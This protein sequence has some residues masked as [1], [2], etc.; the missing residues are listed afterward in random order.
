MWRLAI[1]LAIAAAAVAAFVRGAEIY[2]FRPY[3]K[4]LCKVMD[5]SS[6]PECVFADSYWEARL[7]FR[8]A[9]DDAVN[10]GVSAELHTIPLVEPDYTIDVAVLHPPGRPNTSQ[11]DKVV[12]HVSGTHGVEGYAGSGI[13]ISAMKTS[14]PRMLRHRFAPCIVL[15]HALNPYGMAL[16]RRWNENNV[17]LNRN[18][19]NEQ[20]FAEVKARDPNIAGYFD[21]DPMYNPTGKPST[22]DPLFMLPRAL[23]YIMRHGMRSMKRSLVT[24]QYVKKRGIFY[25]GEELQPSYRKL[26]ALF[27]E[28]GISS[29]ERATVVDVHTGLG[30]SGVDTL[31]VARCHLLHRVRSDFR[32]DH[33]ITDTRA[34]CTSASPR[35]D[36][37][38]DDDAPQAGD[39][40]ELTTG[41]FDMAAQ[42]LFPEAHAADKVFTV[43]QEFGTVPVLFVA[44]A[45]ILENQ[46]YWEAPQKHGR[47]ATYT[48]DAFYVRGE[49]W[50][51]RIADRGL[52]VLEQ[53][54]ERET[55]PPERPAKEGA[56]GRDKAERPRDARKE[57]D[58]AQVQEGW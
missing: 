26:A 23:W 27:K 11:C 9:V 8:L 12:L 19:L 6:R 49:G 52:R 46:A 43:T 24:G 33:R 18:A 7:Y 50:K 5:H 55:F 39:G 53:A 41:S 47:W 4:P 2:F 37:D 32:W 35:N 54:I 1:K 16:F 51:R 21:F 25:G 15:V 3:D 40:Y 28:I 31:L 34:E 29:V 42:F 20:Q 58:E 36:D 13:Q 45:L 48:R 57:A 17:D 38:D 14:I 22:L 10:H 30:P 56:A 44:G